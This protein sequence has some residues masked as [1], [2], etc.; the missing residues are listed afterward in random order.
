MNNIMTKLL[1]AIVCQAS[2]NV[3]E[4][5]FGSTGTD[6]VWMADIEDRAG[7][8]FIKTTA[9]LDAFAECGSKKQSSKLVD[10]PVRVYQTSWLARLGMT[11]P[12]DPKGYWVY[13]GEA[14]SL[15]ERIGAHYKGTDGTGC[16][17][18]SRYPP[19]RS[20]RWWVSYAYVREVFEKVFDEVTVPDGDRERSVRV[21]LEQAWRV[22]YGWPR[23]CLDLHKP[24][25]RTEYEEY[26]RT[27]QT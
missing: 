13:N 3:I 11:I 4:V 21:S 25:G 6:T 1:D 9:P 14:T 20:H 19:L 26:L 23:L 24:R 22:K 12:E 27:L 2:S 18:I 10:L 8:Y 7:W 16:I 5:V 17:S 15:S